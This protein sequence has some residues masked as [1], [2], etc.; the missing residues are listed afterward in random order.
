MSFDM[1]WSREE[2][3]VPGLSREF[4]LADDSPSGLRFMVA[5]WRG[6]VAGCP[7]ES[8]WPK[9]ME[10]EGAHLHPKSY[11]ISVLVGWERFLPERDG[12]F[13]IRKVEQRHCNDVRDALEHELLLQEI[14]LLERHLEAA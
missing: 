1:V 10:R 2:P 12:W 3:D 11:V 6:P 13:W 8:T 9:N 4:V 7:R 14:E 5:G